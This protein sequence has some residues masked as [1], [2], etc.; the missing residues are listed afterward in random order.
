VILHPRT[1]KSFYYLELSLISFVKAAEKY[2][3]FDPPDW[4]YV[5]ASSRHRVT[6]YAE[7]R[8]NRKVRP[9]NELF[10]SKRTNPLSKR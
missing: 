1:Y 3:V 5:N 2:L 7:T 4:D 8:N 6:Y 9:E 10:K